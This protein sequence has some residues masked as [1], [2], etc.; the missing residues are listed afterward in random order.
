MRVGRTHPSS[1]PTESTTLPVMTTCIL[2]KRDCAP[3]STLCRH[4][5]AAKRNLESGYKIWSEAYGALTWKEYLKRVAQRPETGL[6]VKE[7]VELVSREP[8]DQQ[9]PPD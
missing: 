3:S 6:W 5:L 8:D 1:I 7:V 9:R 4:H 2:C